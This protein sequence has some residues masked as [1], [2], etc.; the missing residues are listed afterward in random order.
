MTPKFK[1]MFSGIYGF[2]VPPPQPQPI[3]LILEDLHCGLHMGGRE[4]RRHTYDT[5]LAAVR[6]VMGTLHQTISYCGRYEDT[7]EETI[8]YMRERWN[9][10]ADLAVRLERE[11]DDA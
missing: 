7:F 2:S 6:T 4:F 3:D 8:A 9:R 1:G 5:L 10:Y 11:R